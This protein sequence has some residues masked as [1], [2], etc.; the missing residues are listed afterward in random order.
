MARWCNNVLG[1][2]EN[3]L[4]TTRILSDDLI[5]Y[6]SYE[7]DEIMNIYNFTL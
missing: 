3:S 1:Q 6:S 2:S 4:R 5:K 7:S